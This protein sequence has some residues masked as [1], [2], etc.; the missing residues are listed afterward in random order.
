MSKLWFER[1]GFIN[2][3]QSEAGEDK[4]KKNEYEKTKE[5]VE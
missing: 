3:I 2:L 1:N 5:E 4:A